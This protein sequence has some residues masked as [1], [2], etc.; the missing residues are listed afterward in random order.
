MKCLS[1]EPG[2]ISNGPSDSRSSLW[3]G[4]GISSIF[5]TITATRLYE[6]SWY[7]ESTYLVQRPYDVYVRI[8]HSLPFSNRDWFVSLLSIYGQTP[9]LT[10][11]MF[12]IYVFGTFITWHIY[13]EGLF[14]PLPFQSGGPFGRYYFAAQLRLN[15]LTDFPKTWIL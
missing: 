1:I 6:L 13:M 15:T 7:F 11:I 5:L 3:Q 4:I 9:L 10:V 8:L 14:I 2:D 12:G